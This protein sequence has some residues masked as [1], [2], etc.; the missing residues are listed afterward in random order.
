MNHNR[1]IHM[2]THVLQSYHIV[3]NDILDIHFSFQALY[4]FPSK[5]L[6]ICSLYLSNLNGLSWFKT[7]SRCDGDRHYSPVEG[8][9]II[10]SLVILLILVHVPFSKTLY[11]LSPSLMILMPRLSSLLTLPPC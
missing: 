1:Y 3:H 11:I 4:Y 2:S 8:S 9:H 7:S 6:F 5:N 10:P